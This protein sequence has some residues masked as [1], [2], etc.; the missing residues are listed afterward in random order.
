MGISPK[1]DFNKVKKIKEGK[2]K[3]LKVKIMVT[4]RKR[5]LNAKNCAILFALVRKQS[6]STFRALR[7]R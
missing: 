7:S 1:R 2:K 6:C 4:E 5:G 3:K